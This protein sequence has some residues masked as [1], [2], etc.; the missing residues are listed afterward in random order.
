M[1]KDRLDSTERRNA[2]V[3]AALP[4]FA[5]KGFAATTTKEIASAAG[6]SE[7]LIFKHFPSKAALYDH[8]L[9]S[10]VEGD[11]ELKALLARP[12][13]TDTLVTVVRGLVQ[14]YTLELP[15]DPAALARHRLFLLSLLDDGEY[16]RVVYGWLQEALMPVFTASVEAAEAAGDVV[17]SPVATS[18]RMWFAEHLGSMLANLCLGGQ[19]AVVHPCRDEPLARQAA[20]FIL[21]GVGMTDAALARYADQPWLPPSQSNPDNG[22]G[23]ERGRS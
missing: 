1:S 18:N 19:P 14:Y 15:E 9:R 16:A 7:A 11:E 5:R 2:I 21:R 22:N 4:L 13:S 6:V 12:P 10:C 23:P 20:W 17:P 3:E 8:I